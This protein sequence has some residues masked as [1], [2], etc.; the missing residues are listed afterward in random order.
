M[1]LCQAYQ[2]RFC[3]TPQILMCYIKLNLRLSTNMF[4]SSS[5]S[6]TKKLGYLEH[7]WSLQRQPEFHIS[8]SL[9]EQ[10]PV[11]SM[12]EKMYHCCHLL[13]QRNF[14]IILFCEKQ[15]H[16]VKKGHEM[17]ILCT[18]KY[19][20]TLL[21]KQSNRIHRQYKMSFESPSTVIPYLQAENSKHSHQLTCTHHM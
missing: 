10:L 16:I 7:E 2:L 17:I 19:I 13:T 4:M 6:L 14:V 11:S 15:S 1:Y 9:L 20:L 3:F 12:M 8:L 21:I 18:K 5:I